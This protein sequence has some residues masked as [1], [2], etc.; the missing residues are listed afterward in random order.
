M[1]ALPVLAVLVLLF[2]GCAAPPADQGNKTGPASPPSPPASTPRSAPGF[3]PIAK[4]GT[5]KGDV[6]I[7]VFE[8]MVP[9]TAQNFLGYVRSHFYEGIKIHR[10][11][12]PAKQPPEGFMMQLGDP[13]TRDP[14]KS[15][16]TWGQ[17]DP[18]LPRIQ[19]EF[20][21]ALRHD[22]AGVL[23]MANAGPNTGSSQFF[24]TLGPAPHLDDK[25]AIFGRVIA[26]MDV[27]RAI[28]NVETDPQDHPV[29]DVVVRTTEVIER[30]R[31]PADATHGLEAWTYSPVLNATANHTLQFGLVVRNTGNVREPVNATLEVPEGWRW[32]HLY[33]RDANVSAGAS[34]VFIFR[35][36]IPA[37]QAFADVPVR[38]TFRSAGA[39][40]ALGLGVH[41]GSLGARAAEGS[42][43][44]VHYVGTLPDGRLFDT[45]LWSIAS[46]AS[47]PKVAGVFQARPQ[48][49]YEPLDGWEVG[50]QQLIAGFSDGTRGLRE[51]EARTVVIEP[52]RAYGTG[53]K[54]P[55]SGRTLVFTIE[56]LKVG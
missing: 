37:E 36:T 2:A 56:L 1:R 14:T 52:E 39:R 47:V 3:N 19:D 27:V 25:H 8:E 46:N 15:K 29:Q 18:N 23:S 54:A 6:Y 50:S 24:I 31:K 16:D 48:A 12:G 17:G 51:G 49:Q 10:V 30:A 28:G 5:D 32:A 21:A 42:P 11:I 35:V 41:V 38:A 43:V 45:S 22:K 55:L 53:G 44:S 26:G 20:T 4:L 13:N 40:A 7:E 9:L 34:Q 33:P